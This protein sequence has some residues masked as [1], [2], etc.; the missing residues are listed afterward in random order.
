MGVMC[1]TLIRIITA[2]DVLEHWKALAWGPDEKCATVVKPG[3]CASG[4]E[5]ME[6]WREDR[7]WQREDVVW[8]GA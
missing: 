1:C 3:G 4:R 6:R 7:V 8:K 5:R 2:L